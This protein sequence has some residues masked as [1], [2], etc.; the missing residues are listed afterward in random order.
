[1]RRAYTGSTRAIWVWCEST[2][3]TRMAYGS[4]VFRQG[5]SRP[6]IAYQASTRRWKDLRRPAPN[7]G[8]IAPPAGS[9]SLVPRGIGD[10]SGYI[11]RVHIGVERPVGIVDHP[12][13]QHVGRILLARA[14]RAGRAPPRAII[15]REAGK[16]D[17]HVRLLVVAEVIMMMPVGQGTADFGGGHPPSGHDVHRAD[18]HRPFG[19]VV[20]DERLDVLRVQD[21]RVPKV[22]AVHGMIDLQAGWLHWLVARGDGGS[23]VPIF[24]GSCLGLFEQAGGGLQLGGGH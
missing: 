2:S 23:K 8:T 21:V 6:L 16:G 17:H 24:L 13:M 19:T 12:D 7:A 18:Q 20:V 4:R 15:E 10:D 1:M 14:G 9:R 3:E 22:G 11:G 5:R